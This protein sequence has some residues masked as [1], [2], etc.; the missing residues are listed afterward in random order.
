MALGPTENVITFLELCMVRVV[1]L[2][3]LTFFFNIIFYSEIQFPQKKK[4][5]IK[6]CKKVINK[7]FR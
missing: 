1:L 6:F 3:D 7:D 2:G 5:T 4:V